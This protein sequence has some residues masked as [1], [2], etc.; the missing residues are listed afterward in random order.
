[1]IK[2]E[3]LSK[4]Y[5]IGHQSNEKYLALRDVLASQAKSFGKRLLHPFKNSAGGLISADE[6]EEFWALDNV[7][8][9]IK[10]GDRVGIIGRNGA[11]KSTL[12]KILSRITEPTQGRIE[13][14]GRVASLL[15]VGTGFHPELTG[16]ENV[17]LNG[18]ILGM[19]KADIRRK[20]DE[21]V[22]FSEVEKFLDT[23]VKRYSSG[24][25]VK[26]AF[27]VA[28]HLEPEILIID[29]VLAVGDALFQEKCLGKMETVSQEGR[30]VIFVSH[31]MGAIK[32][33][34]QNVLLLSSGRVQSIG[35]VDEII[36]DY[37]SDGS[38][39]FKPSLHIPKDASKIAQ[40]TE[41]TVSSLAEG[42]SQIA[43]DKPY[44]ITLQVFVKE[45]L[46]SCYLALHVIDS[47]LQTILFSRNF[48]PGK[49]NDD[50]ILPGKH[51]YSIHIPGNL[52]VPG[53]YRISAH[54]A[55]SS[56]AVLL[57]GYDNVCKFEI[58][59]NGSIYAKKGFPWRG[60]LSVPLDWNYIG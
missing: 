17:F 32:A 9:D 42:A 26:L 37:L 46:P 47:D 45:K 3:N 48:C 51:T 1:M 35:N 39:E 7:S 15:E 24:M 30:T 8:F 29:E 60:K 12:L 49:G 28:A 40:F 33:L 21:I 16:R 54:L 57:D 38:T 43:H 11:G 19:S 20:F 14:D 2:V 50:Y 25:Y 44:S 56:P 31:N 18:A 58:Y 23:P 59:D 13:I 53:V 34:C 10:Q 55:T 52:L 36:S 41:I 5:I 4:S 27:A 22:A 6:T